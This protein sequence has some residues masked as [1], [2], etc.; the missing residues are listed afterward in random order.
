MSGRRKEPPLKA[1]VSEDDEFASHLREQCAAAAIEWLKKSVN[2]DRPI[3]SLKMPE[4]LSLAEA[5]TARWI[6]VASEKIAED[7][8]SPEAKKVA[9]ILM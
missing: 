4:F 2:L 3:R 8:Q 5:V 9:S 7:P 6:V 1:V